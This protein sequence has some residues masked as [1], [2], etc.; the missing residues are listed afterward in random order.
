MWDIPQVPCPL[1]THSDT[2]LFTIPATYYCASV[3][4]Q[5]LTTMLSF[6]V[7]LL[8]ILTFLPSSASNSI[9]ELEVVLTSVASGQ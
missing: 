4:S 3:I 1:I 5:H 9:S 2:I 8:F 7:V 6:T